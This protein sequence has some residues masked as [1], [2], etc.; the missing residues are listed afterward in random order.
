MLGILASPAITA[1]IDH[2]DAIALGQGVTE[3]DPT[4]KAANEIRE[5]WIWI[6]GRMGK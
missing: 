2:Q 6:K 1:R 4:G 5:L 3:R